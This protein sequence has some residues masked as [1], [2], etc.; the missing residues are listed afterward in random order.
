MRYMSGGD[1]I[2]IELANAGD[3]I[4]R[5]V[6]P[7]ETSAHTRV[8]VLRRTPRV[9]RLR[10][11]RQLAATA[12]SER[13]ADAKISA[14]IAVTGTAF[15][16][17]APNVGVSD[18]RVAQSTPIIIGTAGGFFALGNLSISSFIV[19]IPGGGGIRVAARSARKSSTVPQ[20]RSAC[21]GRRYIFGKTPIKT[22]SSLASCDVRRKEA[23]RESFR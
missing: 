8:A 16:R 3:S 7:R 21:G 15:S 1:A 6:I 13:A 12:L 2:P 10:P 23:Q 11:T 9:K 17:I 14:L 20:I 19:R 5:S 4:R 22:T 18:R